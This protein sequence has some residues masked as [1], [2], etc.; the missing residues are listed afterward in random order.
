MRLYVM[1]FAAG[2]WWLQQQAQLPL[3][4][5]A[6]LA[7]PAAFG[8]LTAA[9]IRAPVWRSARLMAAAACCVACGAMWAAWIAQS[10]LADELPVEWEGEDIQLVGVIAAMPQ[11]YERSVRF[12][13]DVERVLTAQA[14]VLAHI[15]V[16][17]WGR[18]IAAFSVAT[19]PELRAGE[20]WQLTVRL[21]RPHGMLNPHGFDYEAWLLER[22]I[23]ATGYVRVGPGNRRLAACKE[24]HA[25]AIPDRARAAKRRAH[26][27]QSA[28][29]DSPYAGVLTALA[30]G[31]QRAISQA[32]WQVFTR[33]GV[34]HLVSI[35]G[36][37]VTMLVG[38]RV[39]AGLRAVAPQF[40]SDAAPACAQGCGRR[41]I[42]DRAS[43]GVHGLERDSAVPA[44]RTRCRRWRWRWWR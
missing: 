30:V 5:A 32:Q 24:S 12:E 16:S 2:V 3:P 43:L 13:F 17:W 35:S 14:M 11:P 27:I 19:L 7:A 36:L 41:G 38:T 33:T 34:N 37:H 20:R 44:Q 9:R 28:L 6:W 39:R 42:A 31:D 10:R 21:R 29:A 40:A 4:Q 18:R 22:D 15:A 1:G 25:A 8:L 23:R 26:R